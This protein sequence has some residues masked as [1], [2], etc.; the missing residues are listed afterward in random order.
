MIEFKNSNKN[1]EDYLEMGVNFGAGER[2]E[3]FES[4][5]DFYNAVINNRQTSDTA[6]LSSSAVDYDNQEDK[7]R[8]FADKHGYDGKKELANA[9]VKVATAD[10][11]DGGFPGMEGL[12]VVTGNKQ[13]L[14]ASDY[15][16][17]KSYS[18]QL[19]VSLFYGGKRLKQWKEYAKPYLTPSIFIE[20]FINAMEYSML[21]FEIN[22]LSTSPGKLII[23]F[24]PGDSNSKDKVLELFE[25][26]DTLFDFAIAEQKESDTWTVSI[27]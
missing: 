25:A 17:N 4:F 10:D 2:G 6:I 12:A 18:D 5:G 24:N 7:W 9:I 27:K 19:I 11:L 20:E 14:D 8:K 26:A 13:L 22:T 16:C 3:Q 23:G 1:L 15:A 21:H